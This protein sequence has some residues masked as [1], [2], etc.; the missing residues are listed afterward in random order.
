[1]GEYEVMVANENGYGMDFEKTIGYMDDEIREELHRELAP[2]PEQEFF[3][4]Y[5]AAHLE[6]YGEE[7]ELSKANPVW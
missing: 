2:C 5:A 4:R 6:K 3:D 1:M 7:W